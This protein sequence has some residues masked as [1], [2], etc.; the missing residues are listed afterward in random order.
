MITPGLLGG[1][2]HND[3]KNARPEVTRFF[4]ALSFEKKS[5]NTRI[6]PISK[7]MSSGVLISVL[8]WLAI[9]RVRAK[10]T[11]RKPTWKYVRVPQMIPD[12]HDPM[13]VA[14]PCTDSFL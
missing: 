1:H 8:P 11:T 12:V 5:A 9:G 10:V 4:F 3:A 7:H 14:T 13:A 2:A 6:L